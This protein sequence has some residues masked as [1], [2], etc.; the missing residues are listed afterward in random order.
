[1]LELSSG[2]STSHLGLVAVPSFPRGTLFHARLCH[3]WIKIVAID[4]FASQ[5]PADGNHPLGSDLA[6][7]T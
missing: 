5:S 7:K 2:S 6:A 3:I 1:M 4:L